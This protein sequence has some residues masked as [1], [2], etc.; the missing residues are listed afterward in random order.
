MVLIRIPFSFA[1][2]LYHRW[3]LRAQVLKGF[4]I[5]SKPYSVIV[6]TPEQ[7]N[8]NLDDKFI[9]G[10]EP[11]TATSIEFLNGIIADSEPF[12]MLTYESFVPLEEGS[13]AKN[14]PFNG[15]KFD[16]FVVISKT[17]LKAQIYFDLCTYYIFVKKYDLAK[18]MVELCKANL[19]KLKIDHKGK[20]SD[21]RFCT[22]T[23]DQL[24]GYLQACGIFDHHKQS[25]FQRFNECLYN[26]RRNLEAILSEDNYKREI[27]MVHRKCIESTLEKSSNEFMK[28]A[29]L[30]R[31]RYILDD[32]NIVT[33]NLSF[34]MLKTEAQKNLLLK[35]C[36]QVCPLN[37]AITLFLIC[38]YCSFPTTSFHMLH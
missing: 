10:L 16:K 14:E 27:P 3:I 20:M 2:T 6:Q 22:V 15:Q 25:L 26:D 34:F 1:L 13:F 28:I 35:Y 9:A 7:P 11:F 24:R 12:R 31:I 21:L 18:E 4:A 30:N 37:S 29:A 38:I 17:E 36:I 5:K 23:D 32:S 33:S 8:G 19:E